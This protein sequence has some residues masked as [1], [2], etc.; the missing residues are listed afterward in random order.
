MG[1]DDTMDRAIRAVERKFARPVSYV[2][3]GSAE[4]VDVVAHAVITDVQALDQPGV[5]TA[6]NYL[7]C[8]EATLEAAGIEPSEGDVVTFAVRSVSRTLEV[9]EVRPA[10]HGTVHL[11]LGR[12]SL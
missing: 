5:T 1:V 12:R 11:M 9:V 2:P 8:R 3:L 6:E 10:D 7:D 4:A